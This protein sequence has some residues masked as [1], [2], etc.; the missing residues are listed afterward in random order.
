MAAEV[1][2]SDVH[3][4]SCFCRLKLAEAP[5]SL[6]QKEALRLFG[7]YETALQHVSQ[8]PPFQ[9]ADGAIQSG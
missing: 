9:A 8:F 1:Q 4:F 6:Y 2:V 7:V 5:F 3:P